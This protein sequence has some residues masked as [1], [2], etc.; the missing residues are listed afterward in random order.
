[1]VSIAA[2]I[3]TTTSPALNRLPA[4]CPLMSDRTSA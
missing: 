3:T 4:G 2:W 1:M